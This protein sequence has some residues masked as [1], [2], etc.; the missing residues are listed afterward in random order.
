M[1]S[2]RVKVKCSTTDL[3]K[4]LQIISI[5]DFRLYKLDYSLLSFHFAVFTFGANLGLTGVAFFLGWNIVL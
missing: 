2:R 1:E 5:V 3:F 4:N